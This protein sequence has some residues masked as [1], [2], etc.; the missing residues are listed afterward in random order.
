MTDVEVVCAERVFA[1]REHVDILLVYNGRRKKSLVLAFKFLPSHHQYSSDPA[2]IQC[3]AG[4]CRWSP[5]KSLLFIAIG[6]K[7]RHKTIDVKCQ[8]VLGI[9]LWLVCGFV[10][11]VADVAYHSCLNLPERFS[12]PCTSHKGVHGLAVP[13]ESMLSALLTLQLFSRP[14]PT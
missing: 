5:L 11:F 4:G 9:P 14:G 8:P 12:Q 2:Q 6:H 7:G 13:R 3:M 1:G 10:K